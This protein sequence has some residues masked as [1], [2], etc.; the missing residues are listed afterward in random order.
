MN[1]LRYIAGHK[2]PVRIRRRSSWP[3]IL[4]LAAG[5]AVGLA[6]GLLGSAP[7]HYVPAKGF[8]VCQT[9]RC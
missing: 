6:I 4:T 5:G 3:L 1:D 8:D 9:A 2:P 7:A